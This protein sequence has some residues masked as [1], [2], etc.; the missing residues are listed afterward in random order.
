MKIQM[1]DFVTVETEVPLLEVHKFDFDWKL[2]HHGVLRLE[3]LLNPSISWQPGE[4]YDSSVKITKDKET[5]FNGCLT[6]IKTVVAG[7]VQKILLEA[8]TGSCM[9]DRKTDS[10]SFQEADST[11]EDVIRTIVE[12]ANGRII[13]TAGKEITI[14]KP[15]IRYQETEWEF[16]IRLASYLGTYIIADIEV[17]KPNIWFGI[18]KSAEISRYSEEDYDVYI[19]RSEH[20]TGEKRMIYK[21]NS[22]EFYQLGDTTTFWGETVMVFEMQAA[23]DRGELMFSYL[24]SKEKESKIVYRE[25]FTGMELLGTVLEV[26]EEQIKVAFE[27]DGGVST[28]DYFYEWY[29]ETGNGVYAMP[30][31]G[32]KIFVTFGCADE[33]EGFACRC[34]PMDV[35]ED[36]EYQDR[37]LMTGENNALTLYEGQI[38]VSA[39]QKHK[40]MLSDHSI[41]LQTPEQLRIQATG[42]VKLKAGDIYIKTLDLIEIHQ[43]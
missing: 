39:K 33:R 41:N 11:Y 37:Y 31:K 24:M 38:G 16:A 42:S 26:R 28:G 18:R 15:V 12:S 25:Q 10:Q 40:F 43:G 29:P 5:I 2:N 3:G 4:L 23:Y 22:S 30:E 20:G 32:A 13:C 1:N 34:L 7:N 35:G 19:Q 36:A 6:G 21:V 14:D 8:T 27:I 17:G 9:L